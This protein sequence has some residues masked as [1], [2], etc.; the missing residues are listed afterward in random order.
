MVAQVR[1]YHADVS[2]DGKLWHIR[3]PEVARSTQARHLREAEAM[4]RDLVAIMEGVPPG[5]FD[6]ELRVALP[7]DVRA[8]L[9]QS[10]ALR[11][12]AARAQAEAARLSRHAARLLREQGLPLRDVGAALGV[13]FQRAKQLIDEG[14][15]AS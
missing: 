14:R 7:D 10:A 5:S 2:R 15:I 4:T 6:V 1:T 11:S 12:E 13:S 8:D 3:V 9:E